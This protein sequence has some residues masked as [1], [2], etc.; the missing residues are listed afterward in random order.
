MMIK[1]I[2]LLFALLLFPNFSAQNSYEKEL[3]DAKFFVKEIYKNNP[4]EI[5]NYVKLSDSK[6]KLCTTDDQ[7]KNYIVDG[8]WN[9]F[10]RIIR[11]GNKIVYISKSNNMWGG[12]GDWLSSQD[13]YFNKDGILI[14][15]I[16]KENFFLEEPKCARQIQYRAYYKNVNAPK[17][18]RVEKS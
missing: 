17:L 14:G 8:E 6:L 1:N 9:M 2:F 18:D 3:E 5:L 13:F 4:S 7:L 11:K 10:Y 16:K 15:A 12:I